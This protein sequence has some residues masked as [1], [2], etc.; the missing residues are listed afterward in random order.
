VRRNGRYQQ[1]DYNRLDHAVPID[2]VATARAL[3]AAL[4]DAD[5]FVRSM[6]AGKEGL[7]FLDGDGQ[8][9][10]PDPARLAS[11]T[12]HGGQERGHWPSSPDISQAMLERYNQR[13]K[14]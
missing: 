1:A 9:V 5:T 13:P 11:Y 4:D 12:A 14:P 7:L 2:A 6:P 10:Q 8:P 3:R